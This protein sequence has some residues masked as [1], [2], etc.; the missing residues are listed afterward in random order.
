[1]AF[2]NQV[3][4]SSQDGLKP[5]QVQCM[6]DVCLAAIKFDGVAGAAHRAWL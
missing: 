4:A 3:N 5:R 6:F 1:M 2:L